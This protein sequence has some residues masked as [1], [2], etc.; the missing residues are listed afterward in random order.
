MTSSRTPALSLLA[1]AL[2]SLV[3]AGC[4]AK[5]DDSSAPTSATD[6]QSTAPAVESAP[7]LSGDWKQTNSQSEDSYQAATI[8][9]NA[10]EINWVSDNGD[11]RSL[12]WAGTFEAPTTPGSFSWDSVN[13]TVK[14]DVAMLA[15]GDP[16]KTFTYDNGEIS[17]EASALGTTMTVRLGR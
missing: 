5:T 2:A 7:D 4:S 15:S 17:Y 6:S 11:T 12:Y 14:T 1:I 13:D 16:T 8:T 9:G 10:I 3:L